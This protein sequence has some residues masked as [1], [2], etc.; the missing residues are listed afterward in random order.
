MAAVLN[1]PSA[2][3][4]RSFG[5]IS[6][7]GRRSTSD[8]GKTGLRFQGLGPGC[9]GLGVG[10]TEKMFHTWVQGWWLGLYLVNS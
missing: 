10:A 9:W 3:L 7:L 4:V 2:A 8:L 1:K 6:R 5:D